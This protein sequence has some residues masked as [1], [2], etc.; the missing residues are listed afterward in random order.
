MLSSSLLIGVWPVAVARIPARWQLGDLGWHVS[1]RESD[2]HRNHAVV[3]PERGHQPH[4]GIDGRRLR[5][6]PYDREAEAGPGICALTLADAGHEHPLSDGEH[7]APAGRRSDL[8][9]RQPPERRAQLIQPDQT[10]GR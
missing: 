3:V 5:G 1:T 10:A 8:T 7:L 9:A 4:E 2:D 6:G